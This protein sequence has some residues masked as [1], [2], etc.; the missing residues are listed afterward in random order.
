M[1]SYFIT[2]IC[3]QSLVVVVVE[4]VV[5]VVIVEDVV[6]NEFLLMYISP[7][8]V[9]PSIKT[10][11]VTGTA[12]EGTSNGKIVTSGATRMSGGFLKIFFQD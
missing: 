6:V 12:D 2:Y 3:D 9:V 11:L 10:V 7:P 8:R 5:V 4:D 1:L